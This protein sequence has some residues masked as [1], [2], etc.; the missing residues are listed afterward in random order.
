MPRPAVPLLALLLAASAV[1]VAAAPV[2]GLYDT[3]VAEL[4]ATYGFVP[5]TA[6]VNGQ[7]VPSAAV[8]AVLRAND[9]PMPAAEAGLPPEDVGVGVRLGGGPCAFGV[10]LFARAIRAGSP[11]EALVNEAPAQG[12]GG[13][14][15]CGRGVPFATGVASAEV[16]LGATSLA[17]VSRIP[18]GGWANTALPCHAGVGGAAVAGHT[19]HLDVL[20][21]T[22]GIYYH[23][24][25]L[26]AGVQ[27]GNPDPLADADA[28]VIAV[29]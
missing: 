17:C 11:P 1:P 6:L 10:Y 8:L 22:F 15:P 3:V 7:E 27:G 26:F 21:N 5:G 9:A 4:E 19:G 13:V 20:F 28:A 14:V 24:E 23:F 25:T 12:P 29:S 2:G 16:A 18:A